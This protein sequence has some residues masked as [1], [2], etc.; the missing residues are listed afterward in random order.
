MVEATPVVDND[1]DDDESDGEEEEDEQQ[2]ERKQAS[3][4]SLPS[5][6]K[7]STVAGATP[8]AAPSSSS[9]SSSSTGADADDLSS[10]F[11]AVV[12]ASFAKDAHPAVASYYRKWN[13]DATCRMFKVRYLDAV[14]FL[15]PTAT[16][17]FLV[18][19]FNSAAFR[20][21]WRQYQT[22]DRRMEATLAPLTGESPAPI[23]VTKVNYKP[24]KATAIDLHFFD[25]I[26]APTSDGGQEGEG[27]KF[28]HGTLD[29]DVLP[30]LRTTAEEQA[31]ERATSG[32]G[33]GSGA[34]KK[35]FETMVD[36]GAIP[37]TDELRKMV[38]DRDS[39]EYDLYSR[40]ERQELLFILF[41]HLLVG[42]GLNQ[43][44]NHIHPY[45]GVLKLVYR[46]L[47][48]VRTNRNTNRV[49]IANL[50][51]RVDNLVVQQQQS[52]ASTPMKEEA[53]S[54]FGR[55]ER[56]RFHLCLLSVDPQRKHVTCYYFAHTDAW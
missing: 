9:S 22:K 35:C 6:G 23:V 39:D 18:G 2:E 55:R 56:D 21:Q 46:D 52:S 43:Y 4:T 11:Q 29:Q 5:E 20:R 1:D 19:L 12:G 27:S 40:E 54:I 16:H 26:W 31:D 7:P 45:L 49:E 8:S 28:V 53:Y 36:D 47:L 32:S 37:I 13:L 44:E 33:T 50:V 3:A 48:T 30:E 15:D 25:R 17:A 24:V 38:L 34:L 41:Q 14:N 51:F 10:P 42:G